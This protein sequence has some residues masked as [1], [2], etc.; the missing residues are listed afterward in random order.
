MRSARLLSRPNATRSGL[1]RSGHARSWYEATA[2]PRTPC[3]P[4]AGDTTADVVVIGGGLTGLSAALHLAEAGRDV[5][6]LEAE[7]VGWGG[8][9]RNGGQILTGYNLDMASIALIAGR[10]DARRLWDMALEAKAIIRDRVARHGIDC[11]LRWGYLLAGLKP[12]HMAELRADLHH[13]RDVY[14]YTEAR[15]VDA[16]EIRAMIACPHYRGGLFDA[17]G[18]QLHPLNYTLGLARAARAAGVRLFEATRV[19]RLDTGPD[20]GVMARSTGGLVRARH[21]VLAADAYLDSSAIPLQPKLDTFTMP[22]DTCIV[23]TEVLGAE[24]ARALIPSGAAVS[25]VNFVLNYFRLTPD[26]RLLFGGGVAYARRHRTTLGEAVRRT[27]VRMLPSLAGV[28]IEF[29]WT[30]TV[31]IT[32]NRLPHL[33]RLTPAIVFAQGYSGQGLA[34]SGLAGRLIAEAIAG[35]PERFDV[36]ARLPHSPF[37]GGRLLRLPALLLATSW[38][39]LRDWL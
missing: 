1:A 11:D 28:R 4:L 25:D 23:A 3:P 7:R 35:Q 21:A 5:V 16:G 31:G 22:V 37:P 32:R 12:R 33:G 39:R 10:D 34:L 38:Y 17:S 26:H 19:E 6:L 8:S 18:G 27:M 36:F 20:G 14:G 30:G 29:A 24:R 13:I 2:H 15:V 9:G